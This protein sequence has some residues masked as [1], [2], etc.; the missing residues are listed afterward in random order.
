ML[1]LRVAVILTFCHF[2]CTWELP[3]LTQVIP[4]AYSLARLSVC[5]MSVQ[6]GLFLFQVYCLMASLKGKAEAKIE[7]QKS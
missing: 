3:N 2:L 5:R 1:F 6:I 7:M 4:S